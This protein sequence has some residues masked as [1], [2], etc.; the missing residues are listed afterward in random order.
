MKL[1]NKWNQ[2][3]KADAIEK[4]QS[5]QVGWVVAFARGLP[6]FKERATTEFF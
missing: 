1:D 2:E 6:E 5:M 4:Y 3:T